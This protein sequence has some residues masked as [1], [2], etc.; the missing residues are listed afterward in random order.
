MAG[1]EVNSVLS[2]SDS[3]NGGGRVTKPMGNDKHITTL[4]FTSAT[5]NKPTP[6]FIFSVRNTTVLWFKKLYI[7]LPRNG[8]NPG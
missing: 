5:A 6:F 8:Q 7:K 1:M 3:N 2:P 4:I